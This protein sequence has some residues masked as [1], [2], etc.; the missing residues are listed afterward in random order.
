MNLYTLAT[1][2]PIMA[3]G[4][5]PLDT[6]DPRFQELPFCTG[7][8]CI[9]DPTLAMVA[10]LRWSVETIPKNGRGRDAE[11]ACEPCK[12]CKFTTIWSYDGNNGF[13]LAW[14]GNQAGGF[15]HGSGTITNYLGCDQVT[16]TVTFMTGGSNAGQLDLICPCN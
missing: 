3:L 11:S 8:E 13:T 9:A 5:L 16:Q 10:P 1:L 12:A 4:T 2:V 7:H 14:N 6:H 15:Y